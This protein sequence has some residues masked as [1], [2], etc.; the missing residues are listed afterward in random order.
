MPSVIPSKRLIIQHEP[1][2]HPL[3]KANETTR[4]MTKPKQTNQTRNQSPTRSLNEA[5][6]P[7]PNLQPQLTTPTSQTTKPP[8]TKPHTHTHTPPKQTKPNQQTTNQP[9]HRTT[10]PPNHQTTKRRRRIHK[11]QASHKQV[12]SN[13]GYVTSHKS[14][15]TTT[16]H[17]SPAKS[18]KPHATR[19]A[20]RWSLV[21][22]WSFVGHGHRR[23]L[24]TSPSATAV[25][26]WSVVGGRSQSVSRQSS[27]SVRSVVNTQPQRHSE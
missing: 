19:Y 13:Y 25:V 9:N 5:N 3:G 11:S 7:N 23:S 20:I 4:G 18:N 8:T 22:R 1:R 21:V 14:Q 10:K 27:V 24:V 17:K 6:T 2:P 16:N 12:T 15:V 26:P